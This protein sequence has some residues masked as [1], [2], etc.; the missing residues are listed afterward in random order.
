MTGPTRGAL[1]AGL[2]AALQA[3]LLDRRPDGARLVFHRLVIDA[4][5]LWLLPRALKGS[6]RGPRSLDWVSVALAWSGPPLPDP[7]LYWLAHAARQRAWRAMAA[8]PGPGP[9]VRLIIAG[10]Q[11]VVLSLAMPGLPG[12]PA[13]PGTRLRLGAACGEAA[14]RRDVAWAARK[15]SSQTH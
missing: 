1:D 5:G 14:L 11:D 4:E 8:T 6:P 12:R 9:V 2:R 15:A 3:E 7:A 13:P 10:P